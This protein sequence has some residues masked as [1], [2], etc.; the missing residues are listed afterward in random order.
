MAF[1]D[2]LKERNNTQQPTVAAKAQGQSQTT[3][4]VQD[5]PAHVKAQ[6]IEA[7][8]PAAKLMDRAT[9]HRTQN[10]DAPPDHSGSREALMHNQSAHGKAQEAMSPTDSH[11]G[12]TQ[13]QARTMDRS[14]GMER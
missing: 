1:L 2:F 3:P 7:A 6:A 5:L 12:Q 4:L 9:Q 13:S 14:R 11:K 8:H 10:A